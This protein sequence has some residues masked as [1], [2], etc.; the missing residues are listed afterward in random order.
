[1]VDISFSGSSDTN[2]D[3]LC[4][5]LPAMV[6]HIWAIFTTLFRETWKQCLWKLKNM[7]DHIENRAYDFWNASPM[8]YQLN[9]AVRQVQFIP[10]YCYLKLKPG[11]TNSSERILQP[12]NLFRLLPSD[13][14]KWGTILVTEHKANKVVVV[15]CIHIHRTIKIHSRESV[16]TLG[17]KDWIWWLLLLWKYY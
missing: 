13:S 8:F 10:L 9:S 11:N 15:F 16:L 17:W 7:P 14:I 6:F 3:S 5:T 4:K 2:H 12:V 1:M